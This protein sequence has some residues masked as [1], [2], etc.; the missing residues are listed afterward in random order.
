MQAGEVIIAYLTEAAAKGG[1]AVRIEPSTP[2]IESEIV[3]SIAIF[4]MIT[5]L[6]DR[7]SIFIEPEDVTME[8]FAT[9][10]DI[11]ALVRARGAEDS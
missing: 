8:N 3:D 11:E 6:E 7:F 2:L 5:F 4:N 10:T 1:K 9:V